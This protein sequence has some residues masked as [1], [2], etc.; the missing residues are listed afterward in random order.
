MRPLKS[1][2][3]RTNGAKMGEEERGKLELNSMLRISKHMQVRMV[4]EGVVIVDAAAPHQV[5][6]VR[7]V[8]PKVHIGLPL[9]KDAQ[10]E[11]N[12]VHILGVYVRRQPIVFYQEGK[13]NNQ[14]TKIFQDLLGIMANTIRL[15]TSKNS[16]ESHRMEEST[17]MR[18]IIK[19]IYLPKS[20]KT[21]RKKMS[22]I[23]KESQS[24]RKMVK[25]HSHKELEVD[26]VINLAI[27]KEH[28]TIKMKCRSGAC[29]QETL[30]VQRLK[31]IN[32]IHKY[33][34]SFMKY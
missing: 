29:L 6:M 33:L 10:V 25:R 13:E 30:S 5:A 16:K 19:M 18:R 8:H 34:N 4:V 12:I 32:E 23:D 20:M 7:T 17:G 2:L 9:K 14:T 1:I 3:K 22:Q 24:F 31:K 26:E 15:A 27:K 21:V 11:V 28:G